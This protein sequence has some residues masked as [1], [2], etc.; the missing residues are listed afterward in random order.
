MLDAVGSGDPGDDPAR[1]PTGW[2][3]LTGG[4]T[5]GTPAMGDWDGDGLRRSRCPQGRTA[6]GLE[7]TNPFRCG[8]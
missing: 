5:I 2:P 3:K 7:D 1:I 6:A 4:W 8:G